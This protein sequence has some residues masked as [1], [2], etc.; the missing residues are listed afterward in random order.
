MRR[1]SN[2]DSWRRTPDSLEPPN[3]LP[4]GWLP[5]VSPWVPPARWTFQ[6]PP[7]W[8]TT[9]SQG[10]TREPL[11][12]T[13]VTQ[14]GTREP[15]KGTGGIQGETRGPLKGIQGVPRGSHPRGDPWG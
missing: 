13:G 14:G 8:P 12:G 3:W 7:V 1:K 10:G 4:L 6:G 2:L 15:L 5:L 11:K 9:G